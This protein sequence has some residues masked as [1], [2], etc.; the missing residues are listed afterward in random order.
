MP[1]HPIEFRYTTPEMNTI[2]TAKTKLNRML[3]VEA[4]LAVALAE[5]KLIPESAGKSIASV[6]LAKTVKLERVEEIENEIHHDVM[7]MVKAMTEQAGDAGRYIHYG[8]TS[9]DITDTAT[10]LQLRDAISILDT[11]ICTLLQVLIELA[12]KHKETVC[13]GR[14]HGQHALPTTYGMK[15]IRWAAELERHL[16]RIGEIRSRLLRAK[17][18]GAVGTM[19]S[20]GDIGFKIQTSYALHLG[21]EPIDIASQ[22]MPRDNYAEYISWC[23]LV[24]ATLET[25]SKEI[26]NLQRTE[27]LEVAE[28]F[29]ANQVGSSTMAQKRNPHKSERICGLARI[30]RG[31][32]HPAFEN[33][34]LEHERDLTNSSPERILLPSASILLD[35]L[36]VQQ[37]NI[38]KG[39]E[40]FPDNISRNLHLTKGQICSEKVML[41]L[42]N[43]GLSRQHA[44]ELVRQAT[45]KARQES[46]PLAQSFLTF[47]E[48]SE[49]TT[50]DELNV[51]LD[52]TKYIGTAPQQVTNLVQ[53]IS[54]FLS[55]RD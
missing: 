18:S 13:I 19:A 10:S 12:D 17:L 28:P 37:T 30:I 7:A 26:R 2:W 5:H 22:I 34:A 44:H 51:W 33:I 16:H 9:A 41:E 35:Y 6:A 20:F 45:I 40:F 53:R 15:F 36:L 8:A 4:A 50:L 3:E 31:Y 11:R 55:T 14:T 21:L 46:L 38:L 29:S 39:L 27:I 47:K 52:P 23:S 25:I 32:L 42:T 24:A 49:K 54:H 43:R 1:V 48:I